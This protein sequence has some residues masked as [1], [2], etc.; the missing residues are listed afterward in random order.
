MLYPTHHHPFLFTF[1][2]FSHSSLSPHPLFS[3]LQLQG[4]E[5][6]QGALVSAFGS[7]TAPKTAAFMDDFFAGP[8]AGASGED[9][10][11]DQLLDFS[12]DFSEA[13]EQTLQVEEPE[14]NEQDNKKT[15]CSV[16]QQGQTPPEN[17][18]L[19]AKDDF[20]LCLKAE[21]LESLEWLS[22]FVEDS[23]SDYSLTGKL[24]TK[25]A[26]KRP[27]SENTVQEQPCFTTPIQTKARTKRARTGVR[28][29]PVLSPSF[30]ESSTSSSSST[31][32]T[33]SLSP[34]NPWAVQPDRESFLARRWKRSIKRNRLIPQGVGLGS[35]GDAAIVA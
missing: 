35:L 26:E 28:V 29:W 24:P 5:C 25:P 3:P 17:S 21:G 9:L 6:V 23:F 22:H 20:G 13:E 31:S 30:A 8:S 7:E 34:Q 19:S 32:S 18:A 14:E 27:E 2:P 16:S 33:T 11:V 10:F 1:N 12:N 4:M 15:T